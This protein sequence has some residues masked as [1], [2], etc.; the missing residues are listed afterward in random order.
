MRS[1]LVVEEHEEVRAAL[2][3]WL[4]GSYPE[5]KVREAR[6]MAEALER[7]GEARPD[8][9]LMNIE[10]PGPNGI[11]ATRQLRRRDPQCAVVIMSFHDSEALR[12]A[13]MAAG[14]SAF[15][16]KRELPGALLPILSEL[17][18]RPV[19]AD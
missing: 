11:E 10:L 5:L 12:V 4:L 6:S 1:M 7:A 16:S 13:A 18:A 14:A 9:V 2:R 8:L 15:V 3:A 17:R 19:T